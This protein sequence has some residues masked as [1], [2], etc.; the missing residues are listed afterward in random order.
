MDALAAGER[1]ESALRA[2]GLERWARR[3]VAACAT[4]APG[5]TVAAAASAQA[6]PASVEPQ[7]KAP[8]VAPTAVAVAAPVALRWSCGLLRVYPTRATADADS[9]AT[10]T[11][12]RRAGAPTAL[13]RSR[14][15][16]P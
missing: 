7:S 13:P 11:A 4:P 16:A 2:P 12:P 1:P 5:Q 8:P 3:A 9:A 6:G 15:W 10:S 14:S